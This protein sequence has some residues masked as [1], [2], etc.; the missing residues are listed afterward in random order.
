MLVVLVI[1][2]IMASLAL[3]AMKGLGQGNAMTAANRQILDDLAYARLKAISERTTV[4]MIFLPP[5]FWTDTRINS[6]TGQSQS[7][8]LELISGQYTTYAL[9]AFR[10]IGDQPGQS[11]PRYLTEWK[12]LPDGV[13]VVSNK[14][15]VVE[16]VKKWDP[17]FTTNQWFTVDAFQYRDFPFPQ[18]EVTNSP[19]VQIQLPYIA[20]D[21]TGKLTS[22]QDEY[23]P[24]AQGSI[25]FPRNANDQLLPQTADLIETGYREATRTNYNLVHIDWLTGR[26][27]IE[28]PEL[29]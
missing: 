16:T 13:L 23:I 3:P 28:K 5:N 11:R 20:F 7:N 6:L 29:Q 25:F 27:R 24:L 19:M 12:S 18:T 26:A 14:F 17:T 1:I 2:G 22:G 15:S 10:S 4:Y 8:A 21:P 9:F